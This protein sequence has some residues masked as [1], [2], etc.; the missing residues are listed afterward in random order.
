MQVPNV[1]ACIVPS[2]FLLASHATRQ[3]EEDRT[4]GPDGHAGTL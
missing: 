3:A 4:H 1:H 2:T